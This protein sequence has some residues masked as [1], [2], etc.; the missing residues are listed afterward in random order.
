[1][2]TITIFEE[3]GIGKRHKSEDGETRRSRQ[4]GS[5]A[6][7]QSRVILLDFNR[8][9]SSHVSDTTLA[10]EVV[11]DGS[12]ALRER[13]ERQHFPDAAS[14]TDESIVPLIRQAAEAGSPEALT[15]LGRWYESGKHVGKD[16]IAASMYY[17]RAIRFDSPRASEL[18]WNLTRERS[19]FEQLKSR[20]NENDAGAKA[21]WASLV[22]L[23]FDDQLTRQQALAMLETAAK[24]NNIPALIELGLWYVQ[25]SIVEKD[26]VRGIALWQKA[27]ELGSREARV[28]IAV[29]ELMSSQDSTKAMNVI[30]LLSDAM[31]D[32]SVLA[33]VALGYCHEQ[34]WGMPQNTGEAVRLYRKS[35]QRGSRIGYEALK[36]MYDALRPAD[37]EFRVDE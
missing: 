9:T 24:E 10:G 18:L 22:A 12:E 15:I 16:V 37:A 25:G 6:S 7:P 27:E 34:G 8:D 35:A 2:E 17:I 36:R 30:S 3:R 26:R 13:N 32:G 1:M 4:Q 33:Q 5:P 14:S 21:V 28:R 31:H 20:I 11:R 29:T 23:Q 19:Y